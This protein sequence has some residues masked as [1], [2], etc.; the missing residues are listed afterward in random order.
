MVYAALSYEVKLVAK[1][2][3]VADVLRR[4]RAQLL[5]V[6]H[7]CGDLDGAGPVHVVVALVV[8]QFLEL[9]FLE[10]GVAVDDLVVRGYGRAT[11][12]KLRDQVEVVVIAYQVGVH[13]GSGLR[14]ACVSVVLPE[15]LLADFLVDHNVGEADMLIDH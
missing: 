3:L 6:L 5:S 8:Q 10:L 15:E 1:V 7:G 12:R 9:A 11:H 13:E 2:D 4:E 14:V